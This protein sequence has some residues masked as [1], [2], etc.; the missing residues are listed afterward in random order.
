MRL[1]SKDGPRGDDA[2]QLPYNFSD[3]VLGATKMRNLVSKPKSEKPKT[4][5]CQPLSYIKILT[6]F[7]K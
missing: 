1:S 2:K 4:Y 3:R 7:S 5:Y 6:L